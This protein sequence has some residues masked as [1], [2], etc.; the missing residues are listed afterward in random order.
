MKTQVS[1]LRRLPEDPEMTRSGSP[2]L[3]RRAAEVTGEGG[4]E[5]ARQSG[6]WAQRVENFWKGRS[7]K[8][9]QVYIRC[10]KIHVLRWTSN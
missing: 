3:R 7:C 4:V 1:V 9:G 2:V 6:E 10:I 5:K 8:S